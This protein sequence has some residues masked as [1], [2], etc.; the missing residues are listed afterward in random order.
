MV[1]TI[2]FDLDGTLLNTITDLGMACN[3]ALQCCGLPV[4]PI[5]EYPNLV[6]NGVNKLIWR[7]LPE[8]RKNE[9]GLIEQIRTFFVPY[10]D[11]H[12]CDH[13]MPYEGILDV[14]QELK[15]RNVKLAVASN[16]YNEATQSVVEHFFPNIFDV[17]LGERTGV[18]RK[19][20]PQ[21]VFDIL[22]QLN[23]GD[24]DLHTTLYVGDSL[25]D[26]ATAHAAGLTMVACDWGFCKRNEL[27]S[28]TPK[29]IISSPQEILSV[30][31]RE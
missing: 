1:Q 16:K 18:P 3:H 13:T 5:D 14:L 22:H 25:V 21:I 11:Q 31:E 10:Y 4:H 7:A 15:Q 2:I 12:N 17:V 28:A 8:D 27:M 26:I 19:P 23:K 24:T 20:D 30:Y 29:Y 6:G 9:E